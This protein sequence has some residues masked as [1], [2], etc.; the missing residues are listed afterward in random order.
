MVFTAPV[1]GLLLCM[2]GPSGQVTFA[3]ERNGFGCEA[4]VPMQAANPSSDCSAPAARQKVFKGGLRLL[5]R[6]A[7]ALPLLLSRFK[8][9]EPS[10]SFNSGF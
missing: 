7:R 3:T 4:Q 8:E 2:V 5:D 1:T 9:G 6:N 10:P